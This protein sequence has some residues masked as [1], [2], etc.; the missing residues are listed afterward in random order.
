M[1]VIS[2]LNE[3]KFNLNQLKINKNHL[4]KIEEIIKDMREKLGRKPTE[5][6]FD[7]KT[8][9]HEADM[10]MLRSRISK[11]REERRKKILDLLKEKTD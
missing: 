2:E 11:R 6:D 7:T 10:E 9:E 4:K 8:K 5:N 3:A 1:K